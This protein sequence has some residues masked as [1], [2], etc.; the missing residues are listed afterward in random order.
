[1]NYTIFL[2]FGKP[3]GE[4]WPT[5]EKNDLDLWPMTLNSIGFV[6]LSRYMFTQNFIELSAAVNLAYR[7]KKLGR[8]EY[9]LPLPRGQ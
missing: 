3:N 8:K 1:M 5:K 9:S 6:R 2:T 4:L 7:E